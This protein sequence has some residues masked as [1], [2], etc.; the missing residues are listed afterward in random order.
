MQLGMVACMHTEE[1]GKGNGQYTEK[2]KEGYIGKKRTRN[3][4]LSFLKSKKQT[5]RGQNSSLFS[6]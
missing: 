2:G 1:A 6:T 5:N 3:P 4:G